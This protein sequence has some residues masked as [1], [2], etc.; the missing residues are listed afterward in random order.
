MSRS[1]LLFGA[2]ILVAAPLFI[3]PVTPPLAAQD[4]G[5]DAR[6]PWHSPAAVDPADWDA[7]QVDPFRLF[8]NVYYVG[9]LTV[10]SYLIETPEG[11]I[12]LDS[13]HEETSDAVLENIRT[14]GIDPQE[15]EYVFVTHAHDAHFGGAARIR[16]VTGA[17]VGM[18]AA[19]W[20]MV[21]DRL[22][23]SGPRLERD[24]VISDNEVITLGGYAIR[25]I[26]TSGHAPGVLSMEYIAYSPRGSFR[27]LTPGGL[28]LDFGPEGT[29]G[30]LAGLERLRSVEPSVILAPHPHMGP[31]DLLAA[32][33][34]LEEYDGGH[35]HPLAGRIQVEEWL[36]AIEEAASAKLESEGL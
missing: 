2:A 18:S 32:R 26:E 12:L 3:R 14:L 33:R 29:E 28:S 17:R 34:V 9:T 27:V 30:Y 21:E 5:W 22:A 23:E 20:D 6:A 8:D 25:F 13:T 15:L 4:S 36:D 19:A 24:L 1:R 35:A 31:V 11:L 7:H 10:S 16:E